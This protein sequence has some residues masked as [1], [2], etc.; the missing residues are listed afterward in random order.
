MAAEYGSTTSAPMESQASTAA[1]EPGGT[2]SGEARRKSF[3]LSPGLDQV[4]DTYVIQHCLDCFAITIHTDGRTIRLSSHTLGLRT[5]GHYG[6][7]IL[8]S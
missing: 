3:D 4:S 5:I 2:D 1:V 6:E 7:L 8:P